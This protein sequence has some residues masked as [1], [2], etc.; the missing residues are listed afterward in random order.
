MI[1]NND[2]QTRESVLHL[3]KDSADVKPRDHWIRQKVSFC[4]RARRESALSG[5]VFPHPCTVLLCTCNAG[6]SFQNVTAIISDI[7]H[8]S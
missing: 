5:K 2:S 3:S 4:K 7:K 1:A 8:A 6:S